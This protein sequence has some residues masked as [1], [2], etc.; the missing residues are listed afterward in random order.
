MILA[1]MGPT[2]GSCFKLSPSSPNIMHRDS[3]GSAPVA[4][5]PPL[6]KLTRFQSDAY[7]GLQLESINFLLLIRTELLVRVR[8]S[9]LGQA[10]CSSVLR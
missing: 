3:A 5:T 9:T 7:Q 8:V 2:A 10:L 4:G 1:L 6:S